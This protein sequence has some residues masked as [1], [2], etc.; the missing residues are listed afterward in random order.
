MDQS[1]METSVKFWS[2]VDHVLLEQANIVVNME[3]LAVAMMD[4]AGT[5]VEH[6]FHQRESAWQAL[7]RQH[8]HMTTKTNFGFSW[9]DQKSLLFLKNLLVDVHQVPTLMVEHAVVKMDAVGISVAL[10]ILITMEIALRELVPYG[11]EIAQQAGGELR[12][13]K[14]N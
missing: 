2:L 14:M 6:R 13:N 12:F 4:A 3:Q 7:R 8:G 9:K 1:L 10:Q 11:F 5:T